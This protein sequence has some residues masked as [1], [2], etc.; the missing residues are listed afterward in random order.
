[1]K[2]AKRPR[3]TTAA[4]RAAHA[5][6][7]VLGVDG[8]GTKTRA[9]VT[10]ERGEILGEG[11]AGPSNPLRVGVAAAAT[12]VRAAAE[13]ACGA[14]QVRRARLDAAQ[15]GLAGVRRADLRE[16]M[17]EA[18]RSLGADSLDVVTDADIALH[19]STGGGPGL[20]IIAGTGS[21]CCGRNAR[22]RKTFAGG[23]GPLAGDEGAGS[24]VAREGLR[25]VAR[26]T[27][28]RGRATTLVES[29]CLY[30]NVAKPDDL[31]FA[32]YSPAMT[33]HAIA[34]FAR[35][36]IEAAKAGDDVAREI[37]MEGGRELGL[38]AVTV[39]KALRMER[40]GFPVGYVGG[41]FAAGELIF[42]PLGEAVGR[43]AR[44]AYFTPPRL[45]PAE[46]AAEMARERLRL[47]LAG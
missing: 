8:G 22:G 12:A 41:M 38:A 6:T 37:V 40:E 1:M 44:G 3:K 23:W 32:I 29:S 18:L 17:R 24:W 33:N 25:A 42:G 27:D 35:H 36:V 45:D 15:V 46:A 14:A 5:P 26:A 47:A 20:V 31:A 11:L 43:V 7:L 16:R 4:G 19:G 10:D 2:S 28:G 21:I 39:I 13:R 9:V 30:F 34:G